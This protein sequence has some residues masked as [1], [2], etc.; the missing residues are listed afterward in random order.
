[1]REQEMEKGKNERKSEKE[2]EKKQ[3]PGEARDS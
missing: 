1:M 2:I 3:E